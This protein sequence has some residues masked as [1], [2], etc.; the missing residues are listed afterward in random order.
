MRTT[1]QG[2]EAQIVNGAYALTAVIGSNEPTRTYVKPDPHA[3]EMTQA[4]VEAVFASR[5]AFEAAR[6]CDF[7]APMYFGVRWLSR[8]RVTMWSRME[9]DQWVARA[10]VRVSWLR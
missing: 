10:H 1:I 6:A 2:R 3:D 8:M 7:P 4:E 9:V 5:D